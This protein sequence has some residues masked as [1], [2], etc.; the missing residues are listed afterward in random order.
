MNLMWFTLAA[1]GLLISR[2]AKEKMDDGQ[3]TTD[4]YTGLVY[5]QR[6]LN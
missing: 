5:L 6:A 4:D 3:D 2:Q 1:T